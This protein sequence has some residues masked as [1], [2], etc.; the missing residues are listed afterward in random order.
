ML[1][2]LVWFVPGFGAAAETQSETAQPQAEA[3]E[4]AANQQELQS[5][6]RRVQAAYA[7]IA[8]AIVRIEHARPPD[9]VFIPGSS[10]GTIVTADG[11]IVTAAVAN[12]ALY[13]GD[14]FA[15]HL[16]DGRKVKAVALGWSTEWNLGLLKI[17]EPG[18]W[19]HV[20]FSPTKAAAGQ[21]CI[22]LDYPVFLQPL[23]GLQYDRRPSPRL[24]SITKT[25]ANWFVCK[26]ITTRS[27][28]VF[29][30]DGQLLGVA[31]GYGGN[32]ALCTPVDLFQ[33]N[34][35]ALA[36]GTNLD[37][38]RLFPSA[39]QPE[40]AGQ[41]SALQTQE[42]NKGSDAEAVARAKAATIRFLAEGDK[43]PGL[44]GVI[45]TP[46]G[47]IIT[48]G[49]H[50]RLPGEKVTVY[51]PDGRDATGV[52]LGTNMVSDVGLLKIADKGPWP[53]VE[54]GDSTILK[55]GD[56]CVVMGYP[57]DHKDRQPL[58]RETTV[59]ERKNE[60]WSIQLWT[61]AYEGGSGDSGGGVFDRQGRVVAVVEGG[62]IR[63]EQSHIRV[64]VH[65]KQWT[66]LSS[67]TPATIQD[68][69]PLKE[70]AAA[71]DRLAKGQEPTV[72]EVLGDK[73]PR[74][75]GT[76]IGSD[77]R[78]IT[79]ASELYGEISCRLA[80]G[81]VLPATVSR[82]IREHDLAI[83]KIDANDL[84]TA[85]WSKA[86]EASVGALA[87]VVLR[88]RGPSRTTAS[89][90]VVSLAARSI[91]AE[92]PSL[93]VELKDSDRGMQVSSQPRRGRSQL[94]QGDV[95]LEVAGRPTPNLQAFNQL[96][97]PETGV[98][99][100]F[101]GDPVR[102][103]VRRENESLEFVFPLPPT[104]PVESARSSGFKSVF[105][106]DVTLKPNVCGGPVIDK[107]GQVI[108]ITIVARGLGQ[109]HVLPAAIIRKL[110][111]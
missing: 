24:G 15:I 43:P 74:A 31:G 73:Q 34:W 93:G 35:E 26:G 2:V 13:V 39:P 25:T 44:S 103:S 17:S 27:G 104:R 76:V 28:G 61:A 62:T 14:S 30:L 110:I 23:R 79:K 92:K 75:L 21:L 56:P 98:P 55:P 95:I 1:G 85:D 64:E 102:V 29:N 54:M 41:R 100:A 46:D 40:Q 86:D 101:A 105:D 97:A 49:H 59:F 38:D 66:M 77:G 88:G 20:E 96:I 81:R 12:R 33:T 111:E 68:S 45:V 70:T 72:V 57:V 58:V 87:A 9:S 8:P 90:G 84:P 99:I 83:L 19:P 6:E 32:E 36:A 60:A 16:A 78:I 82:L 94:R 52:V 51:L 80:D 106:L 63:D 71:F 109:T 53:H 67:G 10:S 48:C 11:Y 5:L 69:D 91:P 50:E 47:Y 108:G 89:L 7:A 18:P 37:R 107:T 42:G 4:K 65:R 22:S 3:N